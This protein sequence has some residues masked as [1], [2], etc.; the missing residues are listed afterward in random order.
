[1]TLEVVTAPNLFTPTSFTFVVPG[2]Q[3]WT[4]RSVR[5]DVARAVG[6]APARAYLLTVTDGTS[7]V[8][9]QGADDAG[10]EPGTTSITWCNCPAATVTAGPDGVVVAPV[11]NL[12]LDAGYQIVGTILNPAAGDQWNDAVVWLDYV[13]AA[14]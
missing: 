5:A 8:A 7:L 3:R 1:M 13:Y 4:L 2:R 12:V 14:A 11:P 6:G 10:T 9:Q